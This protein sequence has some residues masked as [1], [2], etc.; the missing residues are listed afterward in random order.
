[1]DRGLEEA[2]GVR[3]RGR[4][5]DARGERW[6]QERAWKTKKERGKKRRKN[7]REKIKAGRGRKEGK[8]GGRWA[9]LAI[10]GQ[11]KCL[12]RAVLGVSPPK[13]MLGFHCHH[14]TIKQ[15]DL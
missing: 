10:K 5:E 9:A 14:K 8:R 2:R 7:M 15:W 13:L 1:L 6:G 4:G 3:R 11:H 12:V